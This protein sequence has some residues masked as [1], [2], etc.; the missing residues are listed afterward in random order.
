MRVVWEGHGVR[1]GLVEWEERMCAV[2]GQVMFVLMDV[3][4]FARTRHGKI[5]VEWNAAAAM[6]SGLAS[7][8]LE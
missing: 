1:D 3:D 2:E 6:F 4:A 7:W 5:A 8:L